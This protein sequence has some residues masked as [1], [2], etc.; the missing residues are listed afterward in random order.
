[1]NSERIVGIYDADGG[2]GGEVR[3]VL[4]LLAGGGHCALCDI[5]HGL[6]PFG[7][8]DWRLACAQAPFEMELIHRDQ[9]SKA[10]RDAAA[11]LPAVL[12]GGNDSWRL[13]VGAD[14]LEGCAGDPDRLITLIDSRLTAG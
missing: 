2:W 3:Y 7:R 13:L 10:Q 11:A 4:R 6:N 9:A 12:A 14:E 5:T 8:K 1:M